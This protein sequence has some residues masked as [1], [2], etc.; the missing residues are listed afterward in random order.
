MNKLNFLIVDDEPL[1]RQGMREYL[2]DI[3]FAGEI[4]EAEN[5]MQAFEVMKS[6]KIDIL[7]TDIQMPRING[8]ELVKQLKEKPL[9][10]FTTAYNEYAIQGYEL[11]V[12]DYLLKPI[13]FDRFYKAVQKANEIYNSKKNTQTSNQPETQQDFFF[14]KTESKYEKINYSELLYVE[15]LHNY[16]S[17]QTTKG[18]HI[19]YLTLQSV[20]TALP[21]SSFIKVHKSYIVNIDKI[22]TVQ[23]DT[24]IIDKKEL[25]LSRS[26]KEEVMNKVVAA[27]L[28]KRKE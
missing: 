24:I 26:L 18:K 6:K 28:I 20:E 13:P 14:I 8:I 7:L 22:N 19:A 9:I 27:R 12:V 16:I 2:A 25:P 11:D 15:A 5:G 17:F 21:I 3:D 1:A 4:S 23:A 10:I